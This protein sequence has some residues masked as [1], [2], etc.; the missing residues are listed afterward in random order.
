MSDYEERRIQLQKNKKYHLN[1]LKKINDEIKVIEN[2]R[3]EKQDEELAKLFGKEINRKNSSKYKALNRFVKIFFIRN[4]EKSIN[5]TKIYKK[6]KELYP[7]EKETSMRSYFHRFCEEGLF[8][9]ER[10]NSDRYLLNEKL[11]N[12]QTI[13]EE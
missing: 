7:D 13:Y 1:E 2:I 9:P 5:K 6:Y 12:F 4:K 11:Q 8:I 3:I 10:R